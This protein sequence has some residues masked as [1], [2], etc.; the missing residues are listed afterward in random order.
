MVSSCIDW[1]IVAATGGVL[2]LFPLFLCRSLNDIYM[3]RCKVFFLHNFRGNSDYPKCLSVGVRTHH[4][5]FQDYIVTSYFLHHICCEQSA[6]T[7][8]IQDT[9]ASILCQ[10]HKNNL[11][12]GRSS[13]HQFPL[14]PWCSTHGP[15]LL[16]RSQFNSFFSVF[17][18]T[19][20]LKAQPAVEL[21][22]YCRVLDPHS[23]INR[24]FTGFRGFW[25]HVYQFFSYEQLLKQPHIH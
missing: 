9:V 23:Q 6:T 19:F 1:S 16:E 22:V 10:R 5:S 2:P 14:H 20:F 3:I 8:A 7:M 13:L 11:A 12:S 15:L 21:L 4:D 18:I 24:D 17:S 25:R